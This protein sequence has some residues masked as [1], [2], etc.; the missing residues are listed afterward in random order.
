MHPDMS[1]RNDYIA[2][3]DRLGNADCNRMIYAEG[4]ANW[5]TT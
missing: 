2:V 1:W 5:R 4:L 3:S